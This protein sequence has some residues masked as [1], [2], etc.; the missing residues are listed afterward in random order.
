VLDTPAS[1]ASDRAAA[2]SLDTAPYTA[3]LFSCKDRLRAQSAFALIS[4]KARLISAAM[5]QVEVK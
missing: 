3:R 5:F 1:G 2:T 4:T